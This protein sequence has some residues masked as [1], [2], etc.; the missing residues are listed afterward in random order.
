MIHEKQWRALA[1][2]VQR[3]VARRF[4]EWTGSNAHDPGVTLLELFA[5]LAEN[6]LDR[7]RRS[8][9]RLVRNNYFFGKLLDA[10]DYTTE[11][12]YVREKFRRHNRRFHGFGIVAGLE[13]SI[14]RTGGGARVVIAP[15]FALDRRGEEIEV[16]KKTSLAAPAKGRTTLV[17]LRYAEEP[18]NASPRS[19]ST[20]KPFSR[21]E[22]TFAAS[23]AP[24][25]DADEIVLARLKR[26]AGKW[27]LNPRF[28][29]RRARA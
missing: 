8:E 19:G 18:R 24:A 22:E 13:V 28:E 5:F 2:A 1:R 11:Q 6:P 27:A 26:V 29:P 20:P 14:D 9:K 16:G 15:G 17:L 21:I 25:A 4:P 10:D 3:E 23:L 12:D 7:A